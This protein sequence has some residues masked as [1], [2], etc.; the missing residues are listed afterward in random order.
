MRWANSSS[1]SC[2]ETRKSAIFWPMIFPA[3]SPIIQSSIMSICYGQTRTM[4][5]LKQKWAGRWSIWVESEGLG[6]LRSAV[7]ANPDYD[8][9]HYELGFVYL[10][11]N[12]LPD[13]R[14]EFETVVRLNPED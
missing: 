6:H 8:K 9:A 14:S 13:A 10:R 3:S 4:R 1:R 2:L 5:S 12:R 11:Q 7:N